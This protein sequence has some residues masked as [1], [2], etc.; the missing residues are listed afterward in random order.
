MPR[1]REVGLS[2]SNIV[3]DGDP[4]P[5]AKNGAEHPMFGLVYCVQMAGWIKLPL[6]TQIG[7]GPGNVVVD[8]NLA[9]PKR[10]TAPNFRPMSIVAK[11][12]YG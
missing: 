9:P 8:G 5:L 12:L 7:L 2:Q 10:C 4:A 3:L 1:C 11:Q 6:G